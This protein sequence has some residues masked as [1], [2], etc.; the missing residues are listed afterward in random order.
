MKQARDAGKFY[1]WIGIEGMA[2]IG[3][4][5][6][7]KRQVLYFLT[8][9]VIFPIYLVINPIFKGERNLSVL[10]MKAGH[11]TVFMYRTTPELCNRQIKES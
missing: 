11:T 8:S 4:E 6:V 1:I 5:D 2:A 7:Y 3:D 10:H 9:P